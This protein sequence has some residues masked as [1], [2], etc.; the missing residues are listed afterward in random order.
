MS[1]KITLQDIVELLAEKHGMTK[2]D[3]DI[4]VRG[5]FELIEEALATEKYVKVKGLGTFKLTEVESRESVHVS[6]GERIE[7]QGHTKIS[8]TPDSGMKDLINKPFAHFETVILNENT[9]LA[10]TETEIEGEEGEEKDDYAA[11]RAEEVTV[12]E[13]A[14][15]AGETIAATEADKTE[16]HA[17]EEKNIVET[18]AETV[19]EL[20]EETVTFVSEEAALT[21]QP[22]PVEEAEVPAQPENIPVPVSK[23]ET[24]DS[25]LPEEK[26]VSV[27]EEPVVTET[28][29]PEEKTKETVTAIEQPATPETLGP[30]EATEE[31]I[32]AGAET[33]EKP[34]EET[35]P[36]K[37]SSEETTITP[38]PES[39]IPT[40]DS[41][42]SPASDIFDET[43]QNKETV[44]KKASEPAVP[45]E[46]PAEP[47]KEVSVHTKA[48]E[49]EKRGTSR[50]LGMAVIFFIL[51]IAC[52]LYW[53]LSAQNDRQDKT[54]PAPQETTSVTSTPLEEEEEKPDS[55]IQTQTNDTAKAETEGVS[56]PEKESVSEPPQPSPASSGAGLENKEIV[57][58]TLADTVEYDITG[59]KTNYTLQEGESLIKVAVK[60]YGSKKLWPYIVQHN[61]GIIKNADRVPVGTTL[62]IPELV[63]KKQ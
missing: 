17:E 57:K 12:T 59:T 52:A 63:P 13:E 5:M 9:E 51:V 54:N 31:I 58:V 21:T 22:E 29:G 3:A 46:I 30:E 39:L 2:K 40:D 49:P 62:R 44:E 42:A 25:P 55:L 32:P 11:E 60:F 28:L 26:T 37:I 18:E 48:P 61:K 6:T 53:Y 10:D 19:A 56:V 43:D 20:K 15:I 34:N 7:I 16:S 14:V 35:E 50:G 4:F 1:E 41:N 33:T 45:N 8:F 47:E 38:E 27:K 36:Q 23:D 24:T